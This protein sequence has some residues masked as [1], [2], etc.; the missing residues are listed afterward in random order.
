MSVFGEIAK[1]HSWGGYSFLN[2]LRVNGE[3]V[4]DTDDFTMDDD[5]ADDNTEAPDDTANDAA[6]EVTDETDAT[7]EDD[8]DDFTLDDDGEEEIEDV[9]GDPDEV[10]ANEDGTDD[11]DNFTLDDDG[12][13]TAEAPEEDGG[14]ETN[15]DTNTDAGTDTGDDNFSMDNGETAD[16]TDGS[17]NA[18][19]SDNTDNNQPDNAPASS[20][21][22]D[23]ISDED[24]KQSEAQIYEG[25]TDDEKRIRVLQLKVN[26]RELYDT[27]MNTIEG[28]NGIP[29]DG[30]NIETLKRLIGFVTKTKNILIDYIETN[31][32]KNPY[33]ENYATYIKFMA[34]F[35]TVSNVLDELSDGRSK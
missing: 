6:E 30:E 12:E 34:I 33:L 21:P 32:D 19:G 13:D 3:E 25:L 8:A 5:A 1:S 27:M 18:E 29:K 7:Q 26:Y 9:E 15:A 16:N 14:E 31:F 22:S 10:A 11:D 4:D 24:A 35:R 28:I 23:M 2:E 20:N 17:E